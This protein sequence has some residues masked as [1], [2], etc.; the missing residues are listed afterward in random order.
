M[1]LTYHP[2]PGS[3]LICDYEPGFKPPEMVK[4][5]PVVVVTPRLRRRA[6][7]CTV[8]PLSTTA[9]DTPEN[10]HYEL[11]LDPPLPDPWNSDVCWVKADMLATVSYERLSPVRIGRDRSGKRQYYN[12]LV[13]K[14]GFVEI[15]KA[16]LCALNLAH[17]TKH[18]P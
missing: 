16:M 18:L 7:L 11:R 4:R 10:Y 17:L 1:T 3:V 15:Q 8:V 6:G 5:R 12:S 14:K 9:P 2:N 13:A